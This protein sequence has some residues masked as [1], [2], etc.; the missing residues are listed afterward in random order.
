ML[1]GYVSCLNEVLTWFIISVRRF[2]FYIH[3]EENGSPFEKYLLIIGLLYEDAQWFH[4][5]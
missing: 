2:T 3:I 1:L 4:K 5:Q